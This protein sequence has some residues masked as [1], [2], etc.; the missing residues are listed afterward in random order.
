M[1]DICQS[2]YKADIGIALHRNLI[3]HGAST[4]TG[5]K[6]AHHVWKKKFAKR[7]IDIN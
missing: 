6:G 7:F 5:G 4:D 1:Y 2:V 3:V